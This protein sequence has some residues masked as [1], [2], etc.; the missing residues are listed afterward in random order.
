MS[1]TP[2]VLLVN[3]SVDEREMYAECFR[4]Q[5]FCTL[6]ASSATDAF[7]LASELPPAAIITDVRL[8]GEAD[9]LALTRRLKEDERMRGVP[10]VV[11][12]GFVFPHDQEAAAQAGCD[13]F[14]PKPCLPDA[15]SAVVE[16]LIRDRR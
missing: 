14:V 7:K 1:L 6:Q 3:D 12:T 2:R 16:E 5:G 13:A 8:S 10:V 15:L 11:L 4:R 9:G